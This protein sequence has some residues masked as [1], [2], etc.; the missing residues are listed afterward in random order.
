MTLCVSV[1]LCGVWFC[2]EMFVSLFVVVELWVEDVS[3]LVLLKFSLYCFETGQNKG[4]QIT[5]PVGVASEN[6]CTEPTVQLPHLHHL[7]F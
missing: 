3:E 5:V 1:V 2:A 6:E 4:S 7:Q